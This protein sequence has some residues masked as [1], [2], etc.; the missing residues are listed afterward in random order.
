M[1]NVGIIG[2]GPDWYVRYRPALDKLG[3]R[4]SVHAIY[5]PVA[6]RAEQ[7]ADELH[8]MPVEGILA[9]VERR[10]VQAVLLLGSDW[11]GRVPLGFVNSRRKPVYIS[12]CL[13]DDVDT[14]ADIHQAALTGG[15][16]LMPEFSQRYTPATGRLQELIATRI[17]RP[18]RIVID[19]TT[20]NGSRGGLADAFEPKN[21]FL[22]GLFDWCRYIVRTSP[23]MLRARLLTAVGQDGHEDRCITVEFD[24]PRAGGDRPVAELR[25]HESDSIGDAPADNSEGT[26]FRYEVDCERGR[27]VLEGS[28]T[29]SWGSGAKLVTESLA[30]ERSAVEVMLDH[31]CRRVVGGLIP[32]ADVADV[33][34]SMLLARAAD[35]SLRT[36]QAV[37]LN[38]RV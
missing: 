34:R 18:Q 21:G 29:I 31:F 2:Q 19:A 22:V 6:N 5:D 36:G 3:Q 32:V 20:H 27:A 7:V 12:G 26:K 24:K 13:G 35:Q 30:T 38:G 37:Q 25:I 16:T 11:H 33:C 14:L 28:E 4:I 15:L 8:A 17:G 10:D 9:L 1:V 23:K